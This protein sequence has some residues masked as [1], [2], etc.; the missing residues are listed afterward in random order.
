M[1]EQAGTGHHSDATNAPAIGDPLRLS[2][3]EP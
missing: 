2:V 3:H 1:T